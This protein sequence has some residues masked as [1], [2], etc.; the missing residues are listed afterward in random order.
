M[1]TFLSIHL[2][3]F[4]TSK[5]QL[6]ALQQS[7]TDKA[8]TPQ[9]ILR[10]FLGMGDIWEN[11]FGGGVDEIHRVYPC[12]VAVKGKVKMCCLGKLYLCGIAYRADNIT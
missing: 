12:A 11:L 10:S 2:Y 9:M 3:L 8:K 7:L 5:K 1:R 6:Q 4:I